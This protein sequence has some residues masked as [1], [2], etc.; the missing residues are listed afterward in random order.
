VCAV[1]S[2]VPDGGLEC[3]VVA[4]LDATDGKASELVVRRVL[5]CDI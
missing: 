4:T 2:S 1:I 3:P 5:P